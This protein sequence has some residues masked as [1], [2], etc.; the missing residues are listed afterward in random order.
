MGQSDVQ[1]RQSPG[2]HRDLRTGPYR[3]G[4]AQSRHRYIFCLLLEVQEGR[5]CPIGRIHGPVLRLKE[6]TI[7]FSVENFALFV[8]K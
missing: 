7:K 3:P 1:A 5:P 8:H 4:A 2:M 6:M